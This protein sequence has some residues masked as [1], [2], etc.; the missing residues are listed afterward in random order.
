MR[1]LFF[2]SGEFSIP[3]LAS[4]LSDGHQIVTAVTQPDRARGRGKHPAPTPAREYAQQR[5]V[6][7]LAPEDVNA[8]D[9]VAH[10]KSLRPDLG[11]VAAFGQKIGRELLEA[12][13][14]GIVNL[15][16]SLLPALRG[17][18]PIQW[19][20]L[21]GDAEAGVTVFRLVEKMDAGPILV[22]RRTLIN[23]SE[24][25]DE[26]HDRLARIGCDAVRAAVDLLA[27]DPKTPGTPQDA[28]K[29]T[30]ARK[31]TK[32][33]ARIAF[34]QPVDRVARRVCGLWSWPGA[35]CRFASADGA[36]DEIVTLARAMPYQG[37]TRPASS[38][39]EVGRIT[40][41][42]SVQC[43][44]SE[45]ALLQIKPAGG[46]LMDWRDFVN[47]RHVTAGD[48]FIPIEPNVTEPARPPA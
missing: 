41:M 25:A 2:G 17:A 3:T 7:T 35:A 42:M 32:A 40:E 6:P 26:L 19:S 10:L 9:V 29:A 1:I 21:N 44:D 16:G 22:Q 31:L 37:N 15:H 28:S 33:D 18:A 47:G 38:S 43:L 5:G 20:I 14:A 11:Y 24:T 4:L 13:P 39:D 48:R 27:A 12:F 46:R 45:L 23:P 8:P 36:R 34:D 30:K